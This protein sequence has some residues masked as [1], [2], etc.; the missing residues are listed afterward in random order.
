MAT[1]GKGDVL[2]TP[3]GVRGVGPTERLSSHRADDG[4]FGTNEFER[5]TIVRN[6]F[7]GVNLKRPKSRKSR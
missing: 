2:H 7:R 5:S 4:Q 6:E 1:V 3:T